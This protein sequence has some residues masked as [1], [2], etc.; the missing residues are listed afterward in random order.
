[1]SH[2]WAVTVRNEETDRCCLESA[3]LLN[4]IAGRLGSLQ[5]T[6]AISFVPTTSSPH[7]PPLVLGYV[8]QEDT[9]L[10]YLSVRETLRFAAELRLPKSVSQKDRLAIVEQTITELGLMESVETLVG[11]L[12][13]GQRRRVTIG[14]VLVTSCSV[15]VLDEPTTG[16]DSF[17]AC[18]LLETLSN[19]AKNGGRTIILSIHQPRSDAFALVSTPFLSFFRRLTWCA[20]R[21]SDPPLR[22]FGGLLRPDAVSTSALRA[23]RLRPRTAHESFR[24]CHRRAFTFSSSVHDID[25]A[26]QISSIDTRTDA[27]EATTTIRVY[28]LVAAWKRV[29][30]IAEKA[31]ER[32]SSR[33]LPSQPSWTDARNSIPL[34]E[35]EKGS[36]SLTK[37]RMADSQSSRNTENGDIIVDS[38]N[39]ERP[40]WIGQTVILTR[41]SLKNVTRNRGFIFGL[42]AQSVM[43]VL[44]QP[45]AIVH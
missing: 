30:R 14:C 31:P 40:G 44:L 8:R 18:R 2:S 35:V 41:R 21:Q 26:S 20:V 25:T 1:M 23:T 9:L 32:Y 22:R 16:L 19:L 39:Y 24:F 34:G 29:D 11:L 38:R 15:L 3:T 12:S 7:T 13:G 45:A 17:T 27:L 42:A 36:F 43:Y 28:E 4:A 5:M 10:P 37:E 6:G 33:I